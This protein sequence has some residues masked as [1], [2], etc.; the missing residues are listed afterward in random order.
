[1][2]K[3]VLIVC[4]VFLL[5]FFVHFSILAEE[6]IPWQEVNQTISHEGV[7]LSLE[8]IYFDVTRTFMY[9]SLKTSDGMAH[10]SPKLY[11]PIIEDD[12]GRK[13]SFCGGTIGTNKDIEFGYS[14]EGIHPNARS[15]QIPCRIQ[16]NNQFIEEEWTF[17]VA[18]DPQTRPQA[19]Y[20]DFGN[21]LSTGEG[22]VVQM[23]PVIAGGQEA[24][25][26]VDVFQSDFVEDE[27]EFDIEFDQIVILDAD[28]E[29][30]HPKSMS[31]TRTLNDTRRFQISLDS[32]VVQKS[33]YIFFKEVEVTN[34]RTGEVGQP[35][36]IIAPV[37]WKKG[38]TGYEEAWRKVLKSLEEKGEI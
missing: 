13:Y 24:I 2:R 12:A 27:L 4:N 36:L 20:Y 1:M 32:K 17:T 21:V 23:G 7:T 5:L 9:F 25:F 35:E 18:I 26:R 33:F 31:Y 22:I 6:D 34:L 11:E 16:K 19:K 29:I 8:K 15:I 10:L 3:K 38:N 30:V 14:A 37:E 28:F